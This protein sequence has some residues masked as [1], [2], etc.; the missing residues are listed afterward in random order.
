MKGNL[1]LIPNLL[2][3]DDTD[4]VSK[5]VLDSI[6][7]IKHYIVENERDARRYLIKLKIKTAIDDLTFFVLDKHDKRQNLAEFIE[8]LT[9]GID[10]GLISDAGCPAVADP[11]ALIVAEAHKRNI[12]I[13]PLVGPSSILLALMASGLNGQQFSFLG[14]LPIQQNEKSKKI[15]EL[16]KQ[17][18]KDKSTQIFIETPYRNDKLFDELV[19]SCNKYT[20]LCIACDIS[21]ESQFIKTK[22]IEAWRKSKPNLHKRPTVFLLGS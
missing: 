5:T 17:I 3:G 16:D 14:Y 22:S 11:G 7:K 12:P 20:K 13:F 21:L 18:A 8:P 1:Y 9:R 6:Q 2:G 15:K 19:K 4:I 10:V